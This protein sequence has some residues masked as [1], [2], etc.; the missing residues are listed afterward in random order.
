MCQDSPFRKELRNAK[1]NPKVAAY[2]A[3]AD[4]D[5]HNEKEF[6]KPLR[7]SKNLEITFL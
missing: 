6:S 3:D 7:K 4:N 1:T 5:F 2:L